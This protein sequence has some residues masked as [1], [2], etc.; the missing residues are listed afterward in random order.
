MCYEA[1]A[2]NDLFLRVL[3]DFGQTELERVMD[4]VWAIWRHKN[5][6][7]WDGKRSMTTYVVHN[8][9][10]RSSGNQRRKLWHPPSAPAMKINVDVAFF[11][12]TRQI[13]WG[14]VLW[15]S[16]GMSIVH[17]T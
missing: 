13:G 4:I 2:H 15:D 9:P 14:F 7:V 6:V 11:A 16:M 3:W 5:Q 8:C 12:D 10:V 17:R 1:D